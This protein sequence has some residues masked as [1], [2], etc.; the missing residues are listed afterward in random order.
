MAQSVCQSKIDEKQHMS[1]R[2]D[3]NGRSK[4]DDLTSA[5]SGYGIAVLEETRSG[6]SREAIEERGAAVSHEDVVPRSVDCTARRDAKVAGDVERTLACG[7]R[8]SR[9]RPRF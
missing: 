7:Q 1:R 9:S 4:A 8:D 2:V 3:S 5:D 6:S